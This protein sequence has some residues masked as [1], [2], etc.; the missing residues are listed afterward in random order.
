MTAVSPL[1]S[2]AES[3]GK[4]A[5]RGA[6]KTW[7]QQKPFCG[8][9]RVE[10]GSTIEPALLLN[11][12]KSVNFDNGQVTTG[13]ISRQDESMGLQIRSKVVT[14]GGELPE[15]VTL[16]IPVFK[17]PGEREEYGLRCSVDTDPT[18]GAFQLLPLPW[19]IL[20]IGSRKA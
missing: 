19:R 1:S 18:A 3:V 10:L 5:S 8:L 7:F 11:K 17:T 9:L 4:R 2:P 16:S 13:K 6:N 20:A 14:E 12:V 15:Q